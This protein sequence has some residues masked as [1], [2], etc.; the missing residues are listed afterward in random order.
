MKKQ[1][2]VIPA[3]SF[4]ELWQK[5]EEAQAKRFA[6]IYDKHIEQLSPELT[7]QAQLETGEEGVMMTFKEVS[8]NRTF[9]RDLKRAFKDD[10][11][12]FTQLIE[13]L[14]AMP[15]H[16]SIRPPS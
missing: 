1:V 13:L 9:A 14:E 7:R 12:P 11:A 15:E 5:L 8:G 6:V 3:L 16:G 10:I 4:S 2:S